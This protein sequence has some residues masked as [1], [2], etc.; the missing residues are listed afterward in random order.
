MK[1]CNLKPR[2]QPAIGTFKFS[3]QRLLEVSPHRDRACP[4]GHLRVEDVL[5]PTPAAARSAE[6][7]G[8]S[9][10]SSG[11]PG[12]DEGR[13]PL[14]QREFDCWVGW[15]HAFCRDT[16]LCWPCLVRLAPFNKAASVTNC[17]NQLIMIASS[18]SNVFCHKEV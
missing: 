14:S 18:E 16:T 4:H 11:P 15:D 12:H 17:C 2:R 8:R 3:C 13:G 10:G 6:G 7:W 1:G 5:L 9:R